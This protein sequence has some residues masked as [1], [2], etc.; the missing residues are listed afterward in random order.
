M[1]LAM[2]PQ[3]T[4]LTPDQRVVAATGCRDAGADLDAAFR[5]FVD[6]GEAEDE[7]SQAASVSRRP[8]AGLPYAAKDMFD[9]AGRA[10]SCGLET[11]FSPPPGQTAAMLRRMDAA[12]AARVGLTRMTKLAFEPSGIGTALNPWNPDFAPGGS[13]SGS[14]AAVASG[15]AFVAVGSD[16]A[17]SVRI[18]ASCCGVTG[19]K[20]STG[21]VSDDGAM[22]LSPSLDTIGLLA[23]GAADILLVVSG[24]AL[25]DTDQAGDVK[26][27]DGGSRSIAV[28]TDL[29]ERCETSV[30]A[31]CED[32]IAL[33]RTLGMPTIASAAGPAIDENGAAALRV[34]GA[35]AARNLGSIPDLAAREPTLARRIASGFPVDDDALRRDLDARSTARAGLLDTV[36]GDADVL[37]TPAMAIRT[38]RLCDVDP[39]AEGFSGRTL[40]ALSAFTRFA[41]Y[42]G[43][44]ALV[45]PT[46]FDDRAMPVG[47]QIIGR[48]GED[49]ALLELGAAFQA[50][51]A[52]HGRVPPLAR[53]ILEATESL[54]P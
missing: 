3:W 35:E 19:W 11:A 51:S 37:V 14:G 25:F 46:G 15:A 27:R 47:L 7:S 13:S 9:L 30:R 1:P 41:N 29:L 4:D 18:P 16:T 54:A 49:R 50:Q 40:Y 52:W 20:P 10:P 17:G 43:L 28:A 8:L 33:F 53:P 6:P 42:L 31:A 22:A 5:L 39:S 26:P 48:P 36:F 21:F 32:G 38:P 2:L 23:R 44:P 45:V 24:I 34:L 12:G